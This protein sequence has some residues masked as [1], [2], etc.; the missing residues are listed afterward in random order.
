MKIVFVIQSINRLGGTE[1]ATIDQANLLA[2]NTNHEVHIISLYKKVEKKNSV[3]HVISDKVI[4]HYV[5]HQVVLLKYNDFFYRLLDTLFKN[6]ISRLI[7]EIS[8]DISFYTSIKNFTHSTHC[9]RNFLMI[10]FMYQHYKSGRLSYHL[11]KKEHG[12]FEKLIFLSDTDAEQYNNEFNVANGTYINN[13]C[14]IEPRIR[15]SYSN[16]VVSYI[17]RLDNEQK[18]LFHIIEAVKI[19]RDSA[20]LHDWEFHLYGEGHDKQVLQE[21]INKYQL[22]PHVKLKGLYSSLDEVMA[23]SD[24][25]VL[26]SKYE[27]LPLSLIEASMSGLPIVSYNCSPGISSILVDNYNGFIIEQDNIK[28]LSDGVLKFIEDSQL[29]KE[30]GHNSLSHA[31]SYFS[32]E[33]ILLKWEALLNGT[34]IK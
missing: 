11:L 19:I 26:S 9:T 1:K 18:Q 3:S 33:S 4:I 28:S 31:I 8:P 14:P 16:H 25:L 6:K 34:D 24:F 12:A 29:V 20:R 7:N 32:K 13:Y 2:D 27:G 5:F 22:Q 21:L 30:F 23:A 17:G 10:H 15:S